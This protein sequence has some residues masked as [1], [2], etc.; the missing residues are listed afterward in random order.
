MGAGVHPD[1]GHMIAGLEFA[2]EAL[3]QG[4]ARANKGLH[5]NAGEEFLETLDHIGRV[6]SE[7]QCVEHDRVFLASSL[8]NIA[9]HARQILLGAFPG[10]VVDS[11]LRSRALQQ[12]ENCRRNCPRFGKTREMHL[13]VSCNSLRQQM[14]LRGPLSLDQYP[15]VD[16]FFDRL[17]QAPQQLRISKITLAPHP[18]RPPALQRHL[19][20]YFEI[21]KMPAQSLAGG[22]A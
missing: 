8:H 20:P 6:V 9:A 4:T 14:L 21:L 2:A 17:N 11:G 7:H 3:H 19:R 1:I 5:C 18:A 12:G 16:S 10:F 15:G 22:S 13:L